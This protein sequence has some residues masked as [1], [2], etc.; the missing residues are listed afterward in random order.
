VATGIAS[1]PPEFVEAC[2]LYVMEDFAHREIAD[3]LE[4]PLGTVRT[5]RHRRRRLLQRVLWQAACDAGVVGTRGH[6]ADEE[7]A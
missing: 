3:I 5:R 6:A 1:L 2:T 4:M 7:D